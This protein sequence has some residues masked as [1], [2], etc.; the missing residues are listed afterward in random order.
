MANLPRSF[1][2]SAAGMYKQCPRR[3]KHRY[4]DKIPD[5]PGEAALIGTFAHH[6]LEMLCEKDPEQRTIEE[7][8]KIARD[9][10]P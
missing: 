3:W 7:A 2:V 9:T 4:V 6:V 5:P 1:S 10:W 8:K